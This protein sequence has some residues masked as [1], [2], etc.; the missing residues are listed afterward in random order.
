MKKIKEKKERQKVEAAAMLAEATEAY[1]ETGK[2]LSAT[3]EFFDATKESCEVKTKEWQERSK[4]RKAELEGVTKAIEIL[5]S[6]DAKKLFAK[7][8]KPGQETFLQIDSISSL[9]KPKAVNFDAMYEK[10]K[11]RAA[12]SHSLRL[13]A[14]AAQVRLAKAGH[15]EKVLGAIDKLIAELG[16]EQEADTKKRDECLEQYQDIAKESAKLEWKIK[17]NDAMIEKL[18]GLIKKREEEK[19]A[20]IKEIE[21]TEKEIKEMKDERKKENEAFVEAKKDDEDAIVL[22][23]KAKDVLME[24]YKKE[25]VKMGDVQGSVKLLQADP[26][27]DPDVAPDATFSDKGKRKGE[28]K[29]IIS[30]MTMIIEDLEMEITNEVKAEEEAQLAFEKALAI[31]EKLVEDLEAKKVSL[32]EAIAKRKKEKTEEKADK[33][34]NEKDLDAQKKKKKEIKEDCDYM[35]EK[36]EERRGYR[37]AEAD[38]LTEAKEFLANYYSDNAEELLQTAPVAPKFSFSHLTSPQLRA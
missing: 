6:E 26:L 24:F 1:D 29:G 27:S 13:A 25:G 15:F 32:E 38:A 14:L 37:E 7:A 2:E 8:I 21:K 28:T 34:D 17:N 3:V 18:E 33:K 20:T 5:T 9:H 4:L 31:A 12:K 16:E 10:L 36:Y 30:I 19:K 11:A 22:L 23:K 35:I